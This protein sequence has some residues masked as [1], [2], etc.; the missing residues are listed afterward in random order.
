LPELKEILY[1]GIACSKQVNQRT[2]NEA[3][4]R[5]AMGDGDSLASISHP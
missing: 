1:L 5:Q 4:R 2:G 3:K